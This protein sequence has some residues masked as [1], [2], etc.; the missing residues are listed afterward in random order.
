[1]KDRYKTINQKNLL[2][3]VKFIKNQINKSK[4]CAV[5]KSDA[6]GHNLNLI[7][8]CLEKHI[9][10][11]AVSNNYEALEVKQLCPQTPCLVLSPISNINL[12]QAIL[13]NVIFSIQNENEIQ[14]LNKVAKKLKKIAYYHLQVNTGMNRYGVTDPCNKFY[15]KTKYSYTKLNGIYSHF[16]TG[17]KQ[18]DMRTKQQIF[19]F[20]KFCKPNNTNVIT[21]ICNTQNI[22]SH[23]QMHKDMVRCG[24]GLYGY[25]NEYLHPIMQVY[26]KI[27]AIQVVQEGDYVGYGFDA[28]VDAKKTIATLAI[29]YAHGLPRMW[30]K[31]GFVLINGH[32]A[33][34]VG[35]ICMEATFVD[36][37]HI[38]TKIGDY[39]TILSDLP[40]L[41]ANIIAKCCNTIPYEILTNFRNIPLK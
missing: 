4:L 35:N 13:N 40:T 25:G 22:F 8:R 34:I 33:K 10:Y 41:N 17:E 21:H 16:G 28:K 11:F 3:N 36:I 29:G 12:E 20:E 37:S 5:I 26:A 30:A 32:L 14:I 7:C 9:D 1:M 24:I 6:Y 18:D 19:Y 15:E 2:L 38:P 31:N 23:P 39:A 27:I